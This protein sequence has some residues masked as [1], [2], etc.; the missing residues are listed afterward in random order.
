MDIK[1]GL[2]GLLA[3]LALLQEKHLEYYLYHTS[4]D[5]ITVC[6]T[7]PGSRIEVRFE[8]TVVDWSIFEGNEDC[9]RDFDTL[10]ALISGK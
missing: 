2:P 1:P 6:F 8:E 10:D 7:L 3:F 9:R 5:D 4:P